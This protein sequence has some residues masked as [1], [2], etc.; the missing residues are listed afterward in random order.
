[1]TVTI[2]PVKTA[3]AYEVYLSIFTKPSKYP[4]ISG[5]YPGMKGTQKVATVSAKSGKKVKVTVKKYNKH[6]LDFHNHYVLQVVTRSSYGKSS[7]YGYQV[8]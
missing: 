8:Y 1:M 3:Y 6:K 5:I 4:G 2:S 7:R